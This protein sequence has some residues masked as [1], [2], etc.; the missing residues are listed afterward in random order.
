MVVLFCVQW[1]NHIT[2]IT[3]VRNRYLAVDLFFVLSGLV[4]ATNYSAKIN[5]F[6]GA[7][8]F[9]TLRFFRLYPLHVAMLTCFVALEAFKLLGQQK[10]G[11]VPEHEPLTGGQTYG[12]IIVNL[13]LINGLG[14]LRVPR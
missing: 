3:L 9:R 2:G 10:F 5:D 12:T 8:S 14:V 4:I 11:I 7:L 1:Q 13:F 6:R